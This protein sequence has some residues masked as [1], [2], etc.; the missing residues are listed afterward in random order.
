MEAVVNEDVEVDGAASAEDCAN[1]FDDA[2]PESTED[3]EANVV[4]VE[5]VVDDA[6]DDVGELEERS[7]CTTFGGRG[8]RKSR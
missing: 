6:V 4:L 3:V 5:A 7:V 2:A 1:A 8:A